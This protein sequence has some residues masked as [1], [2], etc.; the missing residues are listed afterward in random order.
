MVL[1]LG[2]QARELQLLQGQMLG[3]LWVVIAAEQIGGFEDIE[4]AH[5]LLL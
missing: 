5:V 2:F 1:I 3:V 4:R